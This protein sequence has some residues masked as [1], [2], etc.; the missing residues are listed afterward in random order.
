MQKADHTGHRSRMKKKLA[1]QGLDAFEPH[2]VLEILLYYAIPQRNTNDI[3]KNLIDRFGSF[4]AVLDAPI[5]LL[6][7]AGLTEHQA[8]Y[9]KM[10]PDVTRL[11]LL[12]KYH[13][14]DKV[15][16][17]SN[18]SAYILDRFIGFE[19]TEN[20]FLLLLDK[21]GKEVYSGMIG[22]GDFNSANVSVREIVTLALN[23]GAVYAILA[24]SHPSGFAMP[25]KDD[26]LVTKDIKAALKLVK[27]DLLDHFIVA[28][29]DCV[30]LAESELM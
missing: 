17:S 26:I 1:Q 9:L 21:K 20:V 3:A 10:F 4:S 19:E 28:D 5:D 24:H 14:P 27:V 29:H 23:Y 30:S 22:K 15:F 6:L 12:D 2:E 8:L 16:D 7:K 25:S 13:N 11:Y 18:V